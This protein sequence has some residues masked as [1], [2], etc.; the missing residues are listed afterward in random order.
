M[1]RMTM[2]GRNDAA[3]ATPSSPRLAVATTNSSLSR[4]SRIASRS[5]LSSMMRTLGHQPIPSALEL[6]V[7]S[8][9]GHTRWCHELLERD[10]EP[11]R[12]ALLEQPVEVLA[13]DSVRIDTVLTERLLGLI[14]HLRL[15]AL[16]HVRIQDLEAV[17]DSC[18][19]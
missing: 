2:S 5:A 4:C 18:H 1:S 3:S 12:G 13:I 6:A 11:P 7:V 16:V 17:V 19:L 8:V 10:R 9:H 14:A 15:H